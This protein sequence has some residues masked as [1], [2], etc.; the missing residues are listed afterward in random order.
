MMAVI[1]SAVVSLFAFANLENS[2]T[3]VDLFKMTFSSDLH[4][5]LFSTCTTTSYCSAHEATLQFKNYKYIHD[6]L[7]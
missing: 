4:R 2:C 5:P 7:H 3:I 1:Q 6:H